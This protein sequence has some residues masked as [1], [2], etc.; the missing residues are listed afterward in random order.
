MGPSGSATEDRTGRVCVVGSVNV[1][2]FLRTAALPRPGETVAV[3]EVVIRP[4]GK[5][6]NQAVAAARQGARVTLVGRVGDDDDGATSRE[7]LAGEGIDIGWLAPTPGTA[8]GTAWILL[9][10]DGENMIAVAAG[11]NGTLGA[12]AV[13]GAREAIRSAAVLCVQGEVPSVATVMAIRLANQAGVRV[14]F[15]PS[16]FDPAFPWDDLFVDVLVVNE[17]EA[18]QVDGAL[19]EGEELPVGAL[20]ITRGGEATEVLSPEGEFTL[21]PPAV[22]PVDATGAGDAFAGTL[23]AWLAFGAPLEE[24]VGRANAA[25]ALT[26]LAVG[27]QEAMPDRAATEAAWGRPE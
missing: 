22:V 18:D 7:G 8:T 5:G 4:G 26:T 15:N 20:V 27:A 11:A 19:P 16:P 14:V 12:A 23:A 25:G 9:D 2:R 10:G 3:T 24:A 1:D 17:T 13:E 6:A 21:V